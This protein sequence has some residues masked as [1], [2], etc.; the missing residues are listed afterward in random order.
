MTDDVRILM[1]TTLRHGIDPGIARVGI[2]F[3]C[4]RSV[5]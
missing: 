5:E 1:R 2:G 3:R 4:V